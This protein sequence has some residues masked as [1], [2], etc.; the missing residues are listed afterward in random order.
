MVN[1]K[2][3]ITLNNWRIYWQIEINYLYILHVYPLS[4]SPCWI[5]TVHSL[6]DNNKCT[7]MADIFIWK[8]LY[9][10][11]VSGYEVVSTK[12]LPAL[13]GQHSSTLSVLRRYIVLK[14]AQI[15]TSWLIKKQLIRI[16]SGFYT[17]CQKIFLLSYTASNGNPSCSQLLNDACCGCLLDLSLWDI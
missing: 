8:L 15:Q 12:Q 13:P 14:T 11:V 1:P 3:V 4:K 6:E 16:R 2:T 7:C 17:V 9:L 5:V 10:Y